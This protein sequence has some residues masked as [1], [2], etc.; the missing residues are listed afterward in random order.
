MSVDPKDS[1]AVSSTMV[2]VVDV[3]SSEKDEKSSEAD[4]PMVPFS[5]L[6]R[7]YGPTE[8]LML[9]FGLSCCAVGGAAFPCIN[10]A[11]GELL[12]STASLAN[13]EETTRNAVFFMIGV[14]CV[15]GASLFLG[16]GFTSWAAVRGA[17][18]TRREYVKALMAQDVRFFDD[19]K[20]GEL[21]AA[22][23]ERCQ[24]LQNGTAKKLGEFVQAVF[25]GV[26]GI[27]VGFYFSWKLSLVI[28]AGVPLLGLAT[29]GLIKATTLLQQANPA[30]EKA[31]A[32]AT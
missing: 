25:T 22:T 7:F 27:A 5:R 23:S 30:Y 17:N 12:D 26:G 4:S 11:F 1:A 3:G 16:F 2:G 32:V 31:G 10:I 8:R 21:A 18:N 13:V 20:A 9:A 28:L 14:A 19:A 15:L 6:F 29:W 24:E